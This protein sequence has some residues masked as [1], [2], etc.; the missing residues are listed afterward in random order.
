MQYEFDRVSIRMVKD[1]PLLSDK[2]IRGPGDAIDLINEFLHDFDRE[3][4]IVVNLKNDGTPINM[5][6]MSI[7]TV[8]GALSNPREAVK[9]SI[10]SNAAK[11]ILFHNHPSGTLKPSREDIVTTDRMIKAYEMLGIAMVDHIIIG[12]GKQFY[13][14]LAN[15]VFDIPSTEYCQRVEDL[16]FPLRRPKNRGG[17]AR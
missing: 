17:D 15:D 8:N 2:P 4:M 1:P 6:V 11:V 12:E 13:S 9:P 3:L 14:M 7:G 10:L 5:N 16:D